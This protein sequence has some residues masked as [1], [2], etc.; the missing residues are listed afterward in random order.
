MMTPE[1][2]TQ[3]RGDLGR[4]VALTFSGTADAFGALLAAAAL[5][6]FAALV[7][8]RDRLSGP[9]LVL[10]AASAVTAA[11]YLHGHPP[12]ARYPLLLAPALALTLAGA[13]ARAR[14]AQ[15]G[16]LALAILQPVLVARPAPV[17]A[18]AMRSVP[19]SIERRPA[20][21][22]F[23]RQYRGGRLLASMGSSAPFLFE[24]QL[25]LR[26][27]VHEG[28]HPVWERALERPRREAAWVLVTAG[29][30][31]D[32]E[33]ARRPDL[34]DGYEPWLR[35][36]KS[37]LY[38]TAAPSA[39]NSFPN[40]QPSSE[41]PSAMPANS[42]PERSR[43]RAVNTP[44]NTPTPSNVPTE[45]AQDTGSAQAPTPNR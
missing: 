8:R 37:V 4:A 7:A 33:R 14:A 31:I 38:Q 23:Q 25:P 6:A 24:L 9:V 17:L 30:V 11:A 21:A 1:F 39:A 45:S 22:A 41:A 32:R 43:G 20:V 44:L 3:S 36:G 29:D 18:E 2:L 35:F 26:E 16:A 34:L 13:T 42:S 40:S 27:V 10:L 5:V 15:A 12:K 28:N 19:A